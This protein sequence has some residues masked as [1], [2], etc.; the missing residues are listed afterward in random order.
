MVMI[1]IR[2]VKAKATRHTHTHIRTPPADVND[3]KRVADQLQ[4]DRFL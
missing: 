4:F 1:R 3:Q 2:R